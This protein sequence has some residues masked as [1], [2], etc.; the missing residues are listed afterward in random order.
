MSN[1]N[2]RRWLESLRNVMTCFGVAMIVLIWVGILR[3]DRLG[4][5][6][7]IKAARENAN[8][9]ARAYEESV[10]RA[11]GEIDKTLLLVRS[12]YLVDPDHFNI[13]EAGSDPLV[14]SDLVKNIALIDANGFML[15]SNGATGERFDLRDREHYRVFRDDPS[16]RLDIGK[17]V[18][19]R[20][21]GQWVTLFSRPLIAADGSFK[22]V[23]SAA[24]NPE[25][26]TRFFE[27]VD[28][29]Q[30]GRI[31]LFGE[32]G[33]VRAARGGARSVLGQKIESP[34]WRVYPQAQS[35]YFY[36]Q[37]FDSV[38]RLVAFRK[39][40]GLPLVG[41]VAFS[42]NELMSGLLKAQHVDEAV[43]AAISVLILLGLGFNAQHRARYDAA[44]KLIRAS[45]ATALAKSRELEITLEH[46][47]QGLMMVD[48][49]RKVAVI[50]RR[51]VALLD[52][53]DDFLRGLRSFDDVM[54]HLW[55]QGEFGN[56]G[57]TLEPRVR[58]FVKAGGLAD[59][60]TYER[61]RPNGTVLEV[62]SVPLPGGGLVRTFTD[63]TVRRHSEAHI[64]HMA[65]HDELTGLANRALFQERMQRA[66]AQARRADEQFAVL[67]LD[68]DRFKDVND[69][70]GHAAGDTLLK[71]T[72]QRLCQAVREID[73]VSRLGGDE[74]AVVQTA[75]S[76]SADAEALCRRIIAVIGEPYEVCGQAVDIRTS[77]GIAVAPADGFD[78][79]ALLKKADIALYAVKSAGRSGWRF[80]EPAMETSAQARR[81][82]EHD[83]RK[84][85]QNNEFEVLY[86]PMIDLACNEVCGLEALLRWNHPHRG[87]V[88]PAQ[89]IP[90]AEEVGL[91]G[92]IG[93]WVL[94]T[95]CAAAV[96]WPDS[97]KIAVNLSPA[98]FRDRKLIDVIKA[99]LAA[100]GL[101]ARRL[102]LEITET[103]ILQESEANLSALRELRELGAGIAL[104]DFGTGYSSLSHL[105]AFPFTKIKI[106]R[107]FVK[108]LGNKPDCAAIV[109]AVA[110]LGRS[111]N[112]PTI[113]EGVETRAQLEF[114]RAAGCRQ[115]QGFLF[116]KP[117]R[118]WEVGNIIARRKRVAKP[119]AER[120]A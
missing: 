83:L 33:I 74:F 21:S 116:S 42:E 47:S 102:E 26:L 37:N 30:E 17:P 12:R 20:S 63:I 4:T 108:E 48:N 44:Q 39:I 85:L 69:T 54:C 28:I 113:A 81:T 7:F 51:A 101:P 24:V 52:L 16:D 60:G 34:L 62:Q 110:D 109:R 18:I 55:E 71:V 75:I 67:L 119:S 58:D 19:G 13:R 99:A 25:V 35:G 120:A 64:A 1:F 103:V 86:Q 66:I 9:L 73:T 31:T 72:A 70:L 80:F 38:R 29:G 94:H 100:S 53:P 57:E 50:N 117:V 106:D 56:D 23:I 95:A 115:A 114:V 105:R 8:N 49:D 92:Q 82:L 78:A 77:I 15:N 96:A 59:I 84:A 98:Q 90:V 91:I 79:E 89:F 32:D 22:G 10:I 104:D 3:S 61:T 11:V 41:A 118:V 97:V 111:L 14:T 43:A 46:M 88:S 5:D 93:E 107:S 112:V 87:M 2:L 6:N 40:R 36:A 27:V 76:G 45:E 65:S 68:L